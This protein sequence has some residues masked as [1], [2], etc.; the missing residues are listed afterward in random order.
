MR[1]WVAIVSIA[2]AL[3]VGDVAYSMMNPRL[4]FPTQ[5]TALG[6]C[7]RKRLV[8]RGRGRRRV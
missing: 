8:Y 6:D 1:Q 4:D 5:G 3:L 7:P 2:L